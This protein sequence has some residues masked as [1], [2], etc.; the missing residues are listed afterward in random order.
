MKLPSGTP[1]QREGFAKREKE[2]EYTYL[3]SFTLPT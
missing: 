3:C 2:E 1:K